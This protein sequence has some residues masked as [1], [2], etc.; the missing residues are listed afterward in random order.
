[1]ATYE[2]HTTISTGVVA[3]SRASTAHEGSS[4]PPPAALPVLSSE[5][6]PQ[7]A[8]HSA[9]NAVNTAATRRDVAEVR[10]NEGS[11]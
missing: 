9:T 5:L 2:C 7:A 4:D 8:A 3:S 1:L 6:L 11:L 10:M